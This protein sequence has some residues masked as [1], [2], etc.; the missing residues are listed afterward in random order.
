MYRI[1][2]LFNTSTEVNGRWYVARPMNYQF[3][4]LLERVKDAWAVFMLRAEAVTFA[5]A[6]DAE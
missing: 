3:Y 5:E 1:D 2:T 4:S 6:E